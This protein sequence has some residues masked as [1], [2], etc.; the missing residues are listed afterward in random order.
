[1]KKSSIALAAMLA[2]AWACSPKA[3]EETTEV[4]EAPVVV[5][6][7]S[8]SEEEKASGWMLLFDGTSMEGW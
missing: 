6:D 7:N 8:L 4:A 3:T 5:H 1:M 2:M